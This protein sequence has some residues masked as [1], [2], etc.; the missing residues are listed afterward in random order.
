MST[1][2]IDPERLVFVG[3]LHRSGTTLLGRVL[4]DH[5][6]A[7]GF[8][9]TGAT[10]DEGQHLQSVYLPAHKFG[11][12]GRF[13][14]NPKAHLAPP[15]PGDV[16]QVREQLLRDWGPHW[17]LGKHFL[18][19]KSP[20]NM[21]MGRYLQATF[22]GS[23]LVVIMR[24]P[25]VVALSTKKWT[26]TT[27]LKGLVGH[28][29]TAHKKLRQDASSLERLYVLRYEDLMTQSVITL[30]ALG[31]YLGIE[32]QLSAERLDGGRSDKYQKTWERMKS[33]SLKQRWERA[34]IVSAFG[35]AMSEYGYDV[36][37]VSSLAKPSAFDEF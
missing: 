32:G 4:A 21:I 33:G 23:A 3:G 24:H 37:D 18:I 16:P 36:E 28:W 15:A 10:E 34:R 30:D 31:S 29:L 7:S 22:P 20:P 19:E 27:S 17:D 6:D 12:A 25:V 14:K 8:E 1:G 13:A 9:G 26:R 35:E 5:P 2:E 11:G